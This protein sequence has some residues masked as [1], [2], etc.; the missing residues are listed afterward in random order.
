MLTLNNS[1][2]ALHGSCC[3]TRSWKVGDAVITLTAS[4]TSTEEFGG[5]GESRA[6]G[7]T[8]AGDLQ[9]NL[10]EYQVLS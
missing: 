2:T 1:D 3:K 6:L 8:Q 5:K 10:C 9:S 4:I 7:A